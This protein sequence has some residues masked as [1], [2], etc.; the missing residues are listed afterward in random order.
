MWTLIVSEL[1]DAVGRLADEHLCQIVG[2]ESLLGP[3]YVGERLLRDHGAVP[4]V[5]GVH[6]VVAVAAGF[7]VLAEIG[8]QG[9]AAAPGGFKK[10]EQRIEFGVFDALAGFVRLARFD[11]GAQDGDILHAETHPCRGRESVTPAAPCFLMVR[12]KAFG[13]LQ[14]ADKAH[15]GFVHAHAEGTVATMMTPSSRMNRS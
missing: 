5:Y 11:H 12:L 13:R 15:V 3:K 6:A 10:R 2:A 4:R 14:V 8:Q 1:A 7:D 9:L